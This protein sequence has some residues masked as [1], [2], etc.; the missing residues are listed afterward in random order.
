M[1]KTILLLSIFAALSGC[2]GGG[3]DS[4]A[5]NTSQPTTP[6]APTKPTSPVA[7]TALP[8]ATSVPAPVYPSGDKRVQLFSLLNAFRAGMGVGMVAQDSQLDIAA[9]AHS[10]YL[11][12]NG[13]L[14]GHDEDPSKAGYYA[15]TTRD[16][17]TKAGVPST[18]AVSELIA[19][20][21]D[22]AICLSAL[23]N[24][25]YHLQVLT[26]NEVTVGLGFNTYC[27]INLGTVGEGQRM[28][29]TA[30]AFAPLEGQIVDRA[31]GGESPRPVPDIANPGHPLMVR[32]R[33][34]LPSDVLSVSS[35]SLV[36]NNG[37]QVPGRV[38]IAANAA[39]ASTAGAVVDPLLQPAVAFFVPL[40]PLGSAVTYTAT[41]S[42]ARNGVPISKSWSF[43]T[44][45]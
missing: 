31:L 43:K 4:A 3:G 18:T 15:A 9:K 35:F 28:A 21:G 27:T 32:V 26:S 39:G 7:T 20:G 40:T 22:P 19:G 1:R 10:D 16:R 6:S 36:D 34:D 45:P 2:G 33:A 13:T 12:L 5:S 23:T 25:V 8:P 11:A 14:G 29:S 30:I 44:Y 41:F 38:L 37:A 17:A 24:S 42:G